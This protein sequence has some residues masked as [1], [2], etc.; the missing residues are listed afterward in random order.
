MKRSIISLIIPIT[1]GVLAL[2]SMNVSPAHAWAN[3]PEPV[4]GSITVC[5]IVAD[6]DGTVSNGSDVAGASFSIAGTAYNGT[7]VITPTPVPEILPTTM[8]TTPLTLNADLLGN[9]GA[10][11]AVCV[12]YDDLPLGSYFYTVE[13]ISGSGTWETPR[14]ND[15]HTISVSTLTD[16][17]S[18]NGNHDDS[19]NTNADGHI[20]LEEIRPERTLVVLNRF[21]EEEVEEPNAC[22]DEIDNDNDGDIDEADSA[23]HTDGDV[24]N[25]A[26]YDPTDDDENSKPIITV[27]GT[28]PLN[29][30]IGD[31][32]SDAGA[33]ASDEEDGDITEDIVM[34][35]DTVNTNAVG[36]YVITYNVT[37]SAGLAAD[38]VTRT[39][40]V[41]AQNN[42]G[43]TPNPQC[44]DEADNDIDELAD[45]EDPGCH[46]D[47]NP[48]NPDSYD[49]NDNDENSKPVITLIGSATITITQ[50]DGFT[51]P[52]ATA[53]DPEDGDITDDIVAGGTVN[54]STPGTY[55]LTYN[56]TDSDSAAADEVTRT[57]VVNQKT[58]GGSGGGCTSNCGGGGGGGG[59]TI[60]L[61]IFNEKISLNSNG[62]A[63]VTW[64]T[65][66]QATSQVVYDSTSHSSLL[67]PSKS[68]YALATAKS[69]ALVTTHT[70]TVYSLSA[71]VTYYFRPYSERSNDDA[72]GIELTIAPTTTATPPTTTTTAITREP[73]QEYL[74][75]YIKLGQQNDP[76]EVRKLE[77]FLNIIE[78]FSLPVDGTYDQHDFDAVGT[79]QERYFNDILS[80]WGHTERTGYVYYT[81]RKKINEIVCNRPFPLNTAQRTEVEAF[82]ALLETLR[83]QG[84][85]PAEAEIDTGSIGLLEDK[86]SSDQEDSLLANILA[87]PVDNREPSSQVARLFDALQNRSRFI[88]IGLIILAIVIAGIGFM[89]ARKDTPPDDTSYPPIS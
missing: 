81:T 35:G 65:N 14:Y 58:D 66:L 62:A 84:I 59:T 50:G 80:P 38:E 22:A 42:S 60:T 36:N 16:F 32:F 52:G 2:S 61:E 7:E 34:G 86:S 24:D 21:F 63:V 89:R 51:D 73:C 69:T 83:T 20:V 44:S 54:A 3:E 1:L 28:N 72:L 74:R 67:T 71:G 43:H 49:P 88:G 9:D 46:T 53:N 18:F 41:A 56:V 57:T 77:S 13:N 82:K 12:T 39:V 85:T 26:S 78:G 48:D 47:G 17:F 45:E 64:D 31:A 25:E 15:Q 6:T 37:D 87:Q 23:C 68:D 27:L 5:K 55:T 30:I 33:T 4:L 40:H 29:L 11:D 10:N 8:F 19:Q 70:I 75:A 79:F 76:A